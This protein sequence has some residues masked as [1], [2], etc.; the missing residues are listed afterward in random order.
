VE[1]LGLTQ[2]EV[3]AARTGEDVAALSEQQKALIRFARRVAERPR[4]IDE[5]DI[6]ALRAV[7]LD[8]ATILEALSVCMMSA[9]TNTLADTLKFDLDLDAFGMRRGYF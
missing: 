8:D 5:H 6:A 9:W 7:G 3:E 2:A 1:E 4:Q